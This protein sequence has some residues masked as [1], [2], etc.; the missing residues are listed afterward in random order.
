MN[1]NKVK[2][3]CAAALGTALG[4]AFVYCLYKKFKTTDSVDESDEGIGDVDSI[5]SEA[6]VLAHSE[7]LL[8]ASEVSTEK[9]TTPESPDIKSSDHE[10]KDAVSHL[11]LTTNGTES[12]TT[13]LEESASSDFSSIEVIDKPSKPVKVLLLGLQE[14][15]KSSLL[16]VLAKR[17]EVIEYKPTQ[18]FN[19]VQIE[20]EGIVLS[21]M[22][23][24]GNLETRKYWK[25][26]TSDTSLLVYVVDGSDPE[27][28]D[29]AKQELKQLLTEAEI[30]DIPC[31]LISNKQDQLDAMK[32]SSIFTKKDIKDIGKTG[33]CNITLLD[34]ACVANNNSQSTLADT[35]LTVIVSLLQGN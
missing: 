8:S 18:G 16:N 23:V 22:E 10:Y 19:A 2:V 24:G 34:I 32:A 33:N 3:V 4:S 27:K 30:T 28:F 5:V 31:L 12:S 13:E 15:G 7:R 20:K 9:E 6:E 1:S 35:I 25:N 11:S 17:P 26:F 21:I 14:C 29:Q